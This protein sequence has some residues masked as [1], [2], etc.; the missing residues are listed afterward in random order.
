MTLIPHREDALFE[1]K[2]SHKPK[3]LKELSLRVRYKVGPYQNGPIASR[4]IP[5]GHGVV[6]CY[7]P[8]ADY[9]VEISEQAPQ[10]SRADDQP[11]P[12]SMSSEYCE[13]G[14]EM[15]FVDTH[16]IDPEEPYFPVW[17]D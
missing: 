1:S 5:P 2:R 3:S 13:M 10:M 15:E 14:G 12:P 17:L 16:L 6:T 9:A 4:D 11:S 7:D 8:W